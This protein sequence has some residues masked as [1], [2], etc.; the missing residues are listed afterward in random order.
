MRDNFAQRAI[1]NTLRHY[2]FFTL[3]IQRQHLKRKGRPKYILTGNCEGC[4][5]CCENPA[6]KVGFLVTYLKSFR[7][8]Y[9]LWQKKIN[10]FVYQRQNVE[11]QV[12]Y[13]TCNHWD[14]QTKRC[15]SY[16]S[17]PGMCRDYPRNLLYSSVPDFF[18]ECG[19]KPLDKNA[20]KFKLAL[21]KVPLDED[22]KKKIKDKLFLE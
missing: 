8:I 15:D 18:E 6:I 10:G 4:G 5:K 11:D 22:K 2:Y 17:R 21:D 7:A 9:V 14:A 1:K 19:F 13:F 16:D 12:L 3:W 20:A